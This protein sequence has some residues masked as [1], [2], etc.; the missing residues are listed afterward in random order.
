MKSLLE[1][2]KVDAGYLFHCFLEDLSIL[3]AARGSK[4]AG[5]A[6]RLGLPEELTIIVVEGCRD[7]LGGVAVGRVGH[8]EGSFTH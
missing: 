7:I 8:N 4:G 6:L 5:V 3:R 2:Y 1:N